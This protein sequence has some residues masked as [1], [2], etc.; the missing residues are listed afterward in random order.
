MSTF[1]Q[2][3][4]EDYKGEH[5][6]PGKD[7]APL[8]DLTLN[9]IYPA[10][11]YTYGLQYYSTGDDRSDRESYSIIK[12]VHNHPKSSVKIY[13]A[14]PKIETRKD[15]I[16]DYLDQKAYIL[17]T[18]KVPRKVDTSL[19]SSAYF[20]MISKKIDNLQ[21]MPEEKEPEKIIINP[22]D[23]VTL[24]LNYAKQHGIGALNNKYKLLSKTVRADQLF[25]NGD[26]LNE[27]GYNP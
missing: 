22:G 2:F 15:I 24:S 6:S 21:K 5:T 14:V 27:F 25:T 3:I 9:G 1:K 10:D 8:Y 16:D 17:K 11:I 13:R 7:D 4:Q 20:T 12:S 18:G 26:S 19:D 23:W